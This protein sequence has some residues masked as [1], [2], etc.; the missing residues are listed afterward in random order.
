MVFAS[1]NTQ[2]GTRTHT[3]HHFHQVFF[4]TIHVINLKSINTEDRSDLGL[5]SGLVS[6]PDSSPDPGDTYLEA[7]VRREAQLLQQDWDVDQVQTEK[8]T[9]QRP[10]RRSAACCNN[11]ADRQHVHQSQ[12]LDDK[13][14]QVPETVSDWPFSWSMNEYWLQYLI[15]ISLL[16]F[17]LRNRNVRESFE[18]TW[19]DT[20]STKLQSIW[21]KTE[22]L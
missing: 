19:D 5:V 20:K 2:A 13:H 21:T 14:N 9:L 4:F 17:R 1:C 22:N 3:Q 10:G 12:A 11:T 18:E 6:G 8:G 15:N 7:F 16:P